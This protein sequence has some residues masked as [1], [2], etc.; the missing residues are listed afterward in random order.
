MARKKWGQD[1]RIDSIE[2]YYCG[3][4]ALEFEEIRDFAVVFYF[5][6]FRFRHVLHINLQVGCLQCKCSEF[7]S[8]RT[9]QIWCHTLQ[10]G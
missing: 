3:T 7:G 5:K 4:V 8:K 6:N 1:S 10:E 2:S 9:Y